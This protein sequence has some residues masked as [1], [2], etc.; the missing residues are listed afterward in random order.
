M[1][2]KRGGAHLEHLLNS[3]RNN[4][5][6]LSRCSGSI[7]NMIVKNNRTLILPKS[8]FRINLIMKS[9][10]SNTEP[11]QTGA[12]HLRLDKLTDDAWSRKY[13]VCSQV[14]KPNEHCQ[15][16]SH[17]IKLQCC[18]R[19][20]RT[21]PPTFWRYLAV[22]EERPHP[23]DDLL[24][25]DGERVHVSLLC[26]ADVTEGLRRPQE[27]GR[28]PQSPWRRAAAVSERYRQRHL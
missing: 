1:V 18:N 25:D 16:N 3:I 22:Y 27:L 4:C 6:F 13:H 8:R 20:R 19:S 21:K 12:L 10:A 9:K 14:S 11:A 23:H 28:C 2:M 7:I 17:K 26:A 24:H 5:F 15:V